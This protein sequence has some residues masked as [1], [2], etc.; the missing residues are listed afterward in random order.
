MPNAKSNI[1]IR[2][3]E[4]TCVVV[5]V[6]PDEQ[7]AEDGLKG[8]AEWRDHHPEI[9]ATAEDNFYLEGDVTNLM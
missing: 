2:T 7:A 5:T 3:D 1:S 9:L 8:V 4:F 6:Y